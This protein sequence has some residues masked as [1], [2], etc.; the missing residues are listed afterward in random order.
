MPTTVFYSLQLQNNQDRCSTPIRATETFQSS[1]PLS[2]TESLRN[3]TEANEEE[4]IISR[5]EISI[6]RVNEITINQ[7]RWIKGKALCSIHVFFLS[8]MKLPDIIVIFFFCVCGV[9]TTLLLCLS[10]GWATGVPWSS[11]LA[12]GSSVTAAEEPTATPTCSSASEAPTVFL[13][14]GCSRRTERPPRPPQTHHKPRLSRLWHH[15]VNHLNPPESEHGFYILY[16][17]M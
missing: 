17:G 14:H 13:S 10:A 12:S 6:S 5:N 4:F 7:S 3:K 11:G 15:R 9:F 8:V 1:C 16:R 2:G